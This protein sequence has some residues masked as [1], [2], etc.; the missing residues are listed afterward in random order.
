MCASLLLL[1]LLLCCCQLLLQCVECPECLL[2]SLIR[3]GLGGGEE[4]GT[5]DS[6]RTADSAACLPPGHMILYVPDYQALIG[7]VLSLLY[8]PGLKMLTCRAIQNRY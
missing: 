8:A 7:Q 2:L 4:D 5:R 3:G 1:L 6:T